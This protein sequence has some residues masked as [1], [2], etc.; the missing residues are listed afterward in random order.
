MPIT[1]SRLK[2]RDGCVGHRDCPT[3]PTYDTPDRN[4][5]RHQ[6]PGITAY[7]A[8]VGTLEH[9]QQI[10]AHESLP[11]TKLYDRTSDQITLDEIEALQ[12]EPSSDRKTCW[13][14][15]E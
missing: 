14:I 12:F 11:T 15:P 9:A 3:R 6:G 13:D 4:R 7:L 2:R 8:Y 5:Y 10:A 1:K